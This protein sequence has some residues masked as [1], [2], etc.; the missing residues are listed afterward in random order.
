MIRIF[1]G[2]PGAGKTTLCCKMAKKAR[3]NYAAVY[4]NFKNTV[5]DARSCNVEG[6]GTWTFQHGSYICL[7]EAGIDYN[8]RA[9]KN[10]KNMNQA[11][12]SWFKKHRHYR[13]D[14]DCFSQS[15]DD[16]DITLRRLATELWYMRKIGPFTLSRR[17]YKSVM[18]DPETHQIVDGYDMASKLWLLF[19]PLQLGWPFPK[20][21][22]LTFRPFYYKYFDSWECDD[23]PVKEFPC[24]SSSDPLPLDNKLVDEPVPDFVQL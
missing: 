15:W 3:K 8:N 19:W 20:K 4:L 5:P 23:L 12:I 11:A 7:D 14:L 17:V 6:L 9:F 13:C 1:F 18:V 16:I 2:S 24:L 10:N 22:S 21:F